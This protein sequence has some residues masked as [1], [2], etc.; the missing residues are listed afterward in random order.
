MIAGIGSIQG[1]FVA[2]LLIG[3]VDTVGKVVLPQAAGVLVY[4]LMTII[5]LWK[6]NGLFKAET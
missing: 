6:P 2:S 3:F 5:L 1:A 4:V